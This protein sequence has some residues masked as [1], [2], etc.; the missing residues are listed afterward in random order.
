M[1]AEVFD[2]A[3]VLDRARQNGRVPPVDGS[4]ATE[5]FGEAFVT[6][7]DE[8]RKRMVDS[9]DEALP[10]VLGEYVRGMVSVPS[11]LAERVEDA[12]E[13]LV[14]RPFSR[15]RSEAIR[16][17]GSSGFWPP[18][19]GKIRGEAS[20][21]RDELAVRRRSADAV[22]ALAVDSARVVDGELR[23]RRGEAVA[24]VPGALLLA[25]LGSRN[26]IGT[27]TGD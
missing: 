5:R 10:K 2:L 18:R 7:I 13:E 17:P 1:T 4:V 23:T 14:V 22:R 15:A 21:R 27:A 26:G 12:A 16:P 20:P 25:R 8:L 9:P 19:F 24:L 6:H 11:D 3:R